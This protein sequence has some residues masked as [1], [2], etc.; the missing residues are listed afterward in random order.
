[1]HGKHLKMLRAGKE[2]LLNHSI[3]LYLS[4]YL[5]KKKTV[6]RV[7]QNSCSTYRTDH[8]WNC[9]THIPFQCLPANIQFI[10]FPS[11]PVV[12]ATNF[13]PVIQLLTAG[14]LLSMGHKLKHP[15]TLVTFPF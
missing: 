4:G 12:N 6:T 11:N 1:M 13:F 10:L 7:L 9:S 8:Q 5:S 3:E 14:Y 2:R 15:D